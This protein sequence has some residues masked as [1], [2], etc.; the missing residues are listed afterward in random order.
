MDGL[1]GWRRAERGPP[2]GLASSV[3]S[4]DVLFSSVRVV[5]ERPAAQP[6][7]VPEAVAEPD[8]VGPVGAAVDV[9]VVL[10][11]PGPLLA[12]LGRGDLVGAGGAASA[13]EP[14]DGHRMLVDLGPR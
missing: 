11:V 7:P 4:P 2:Y 8:P 14:G 9:D 10:D 3:L 1:I 12:G 6:E 5:I 13:V